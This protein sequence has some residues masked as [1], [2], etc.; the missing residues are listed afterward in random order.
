[1][2][3]SYSVGGVKSASARRY[4]TSASTSAPRTATT[5]SRNRSRT[6]AVRPSDGH[7]GRTIATAPA[8]AS[9][10]DRER[11]QEPPPLVGVEDRQR[12][13]DRNDL[14]EREDGDGQGE[15]DGSAN[16]Q[17]RREGDRRDADEDGAD[18]ERDHCDASCTTPVV[19]VASTPE[20]ETAAPKAVAGYRPT[21]RGT[22]ARG[23]RSR[24]A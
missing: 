10:D 1:M 14:G 22:R 8:V 15:R 6:T 20:R 3:T 13:R 9:G 12:V 23:V 5:G 17:E 4:P 2:R 19:G 24:R 16:A 11:H 18:R 7:A 21:R